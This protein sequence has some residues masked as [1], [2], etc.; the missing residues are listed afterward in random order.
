MFM[1]IMSKIKFGPAGIGPVKDAVSNLEMFH[2]LGLKAA[3]VGFTYGAYIKNKDDALEI[4]KAA[5]RLGI[6]L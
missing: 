3:E 1:D 5:K 4:G 6:Q 2:E